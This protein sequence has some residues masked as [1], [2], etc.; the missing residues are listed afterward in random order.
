MKYISG[1][2]LLM[3]LTALLVEL[4]T[5]QSG[6]KEKTNK[7]LYVCQPCGQ[8]CDK[9]VYDAPGTCP[10]CHMKLVEKSTVTFKTISPS[11]IS[12]YVKTHPDVVLLD[13]RT[14]EEFEGRANPN[15]GTLKNA[16]NIPVQDLES[17]L[18]SIAYLK[19]KKIIVYCSHSH[20]SEVAC[21]LLTQNGFQDITNMSGGMSVMKPD[22]FIK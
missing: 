16:I 7:I 9:T 19:K 6:Q 3:I 13:V 8:D 15:Y 18:A 2:L 20:R 22:E 4:S 12:S 21:Y 1:F 5:A 14:K 17:R 10:H 11:E